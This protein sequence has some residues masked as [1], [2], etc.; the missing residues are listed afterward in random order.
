MT[1]GVKIIGCTTIRKTTS[2]SDRSE[3]KALTKSTWV[4]HHN[5]VPHPKQTSR[6]TKETVAADRKFNQHV[7]HCNK[8]RQEM[9]NHE[10]NSRD[11]N[12]KII[13][14]VTYEWQPG[15]VA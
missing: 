7:R 11:W 3:R 15:T 12:A 5:M 8:L 13:D 1:S 10:R 9:A 6:P 2:V 4:N 14:G